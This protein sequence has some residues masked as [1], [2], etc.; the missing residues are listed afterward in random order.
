MTDPNLDKAVLRDP[1]TAMRRLSAV[2]PNQLRTALATALS[3]PAGDPRALPIVD[4]LES[5]YKQ[6]EGMPAVMRAQ[7]VRQLQSSRPGLIQTLH[8][9]L[10]AGA[11]VLQLYADA[12]SCWDDGQLMVVAEGLLQCPP[13][14][15][16]RPCTRGL[17]VRLHRAGKHAEMAALMPRLD[18]L[19]YLDLCA[20]EAWWRGL[21]GP[22]MPD[23]TRVLRYLADA[24][25]WHSSAEERAAALQFCQQIPQRL[26]AEA[27]AK[28]A[29]TIRIA[30]LR[31]DDPP[32]RAF[33]SQLGASLPNSRRW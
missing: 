33:L 32:L 12:L 8:E 16:R 2:D 26:D 30:A 22:A 6:P 13:G 18:L 23:L 28:L 9:R 31:I 10:R 17:L 3:A 15:Q 24:L 25:N 29:D 19:E 4:L 27:Q 14:P 11:A 7:T 5:A 21:F 20:S 1:L